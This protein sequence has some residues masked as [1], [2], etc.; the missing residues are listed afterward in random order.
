[1]GPEFMTETHLSST[2]GDL[3]VQGTQARYNS[4]VC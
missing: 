2:G 1:M 3:L 4:G